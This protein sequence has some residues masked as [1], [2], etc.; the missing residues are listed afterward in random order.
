LPRQLN[1]MLQ[2]RWIKLK[3]QSNAHKQKPGRNFGRVLN[4]G[5]VN[6]GAKS[7]Q[8][9]SDQLQTSTRRKRQP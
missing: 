4:Q 3:A 6:S 7:D 9:K 5:A 1:S 2:P 8:F